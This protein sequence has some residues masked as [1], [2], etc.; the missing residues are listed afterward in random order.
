MAWVDDVLKGENLLTTAVIGVGA[1]V[2]LPVLRPALKT[3]VKGGVIAYD[4]A[5]RV[6]DET[7]Q[8]IQ[9][10]ADEARTGARETR[11]NVRSKSGSPAHEG[12]STSS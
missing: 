5:C 11:T 3:A 8:T 4:W 6:A 12:G 7:R 2:L 10:T 9:E 1:A